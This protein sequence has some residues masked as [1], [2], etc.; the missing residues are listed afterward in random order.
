MS[1]LSVSNLTASYGPQPV[2]AGVSVRF[3]P[4]RLT[5]LA[6]PNGCGKSTLLKAI[7][8]FLPRAQGVIELDGKSVDGLGRRILARR[9]AY[10]PQECVCPDY[11]TVGELVELSGHSRYALLGGSSERDRALF[12]EAL[13]TVGLADDVDRHVNTLSGGQR[14]RAWIAMVLA[15][16]TDVILLDEPV[17]HLD[18]KFQYAVLGLVRSIAAHQGKTVVV[19]VHD[20]NLAATFADDIVM[21]NAGRIVAAGPV[22]EAMTA[23]NIERAFDIKS[24]IVENEGRLVC[25]P[26]VD[27][28]SAAPA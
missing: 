17:N 18:V 23:A 4:G 1:A 12:R 28:V 9:V 5:V 26:R 16:D 24:D 15:Q 27:A 3:A 13:K 20:L 10:L 7:M 25:L 2:L 11:M 22:R 6:G 8:G 21:L 19:V 14:Q